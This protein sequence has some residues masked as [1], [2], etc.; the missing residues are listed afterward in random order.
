MKN[1]LAGLDFFSEIFGRHKFL[2]WS[3]KKSMI[4]NLKIGDCNFSLYMQNYEK[5]SKPH[6]N[7]K[8]WKKI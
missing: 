5:N 8:Y 3:E 4:E 6:E 1:I 7:D 2:V